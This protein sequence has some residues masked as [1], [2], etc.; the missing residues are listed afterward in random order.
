MSD[1]PQQGRC[2]HRW[3][4]QVG[5]E[6]YGDDPAAFVVGKDAP[7]TSLVDALLRRGIEV[8]NVDAAVLDDDAIWPPAVRSTVVDFM[9]D[10]EA[11]PVAFTVDHR[12]G[13]HDT[14]SVV[15]RDDASDPARLVLRSSWHSWIPPDPPTPSS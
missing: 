14:V 7:G 4:P 13:Q 10:A 6:A 15:S 12:L 2:G 8:R 5:L 3:P 1:D 9:Q 11:R